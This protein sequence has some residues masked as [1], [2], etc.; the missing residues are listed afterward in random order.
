MPL[1]LHFEGGISRISEVNVT[2][3]KRR[4]RACL[5]YLHSCE[6]VGTATGPLQEEGLGE[7][8]LPGR[9]LWA[10]HWSHWCHGLSEQREAD[11]SGRVP[12]QCA[13]ETWSILTNGSVTRCVV[14][15][16]DNY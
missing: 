10:L 14:L 13:V 8:H 9:R 1:K 6:V 7:R 15:H 12:G 16:L 3:E 5:W 4:P 2:E 11:D